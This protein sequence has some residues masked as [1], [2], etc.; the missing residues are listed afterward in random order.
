MVSVSVAS[1][2]EEQKL[3][4]IVALWSARKPAAFFDEIPWLVPQWDLEEARR[5]LRNGY[6]DY[7]SGRCI[8]ISTREDEW[9]LSLYDRDVP[10]GGKTGLQIYEVVKEQLSI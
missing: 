2:S 4:F 1:W 5:N 10:K 3:F 9:D 8:K 7:T 6:I